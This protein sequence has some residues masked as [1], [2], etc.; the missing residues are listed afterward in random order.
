[1]LL[2]GAYRHLIVAFIETEGNC[3]R[4]KLFAAGEVA[5]QSHNSLK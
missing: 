5:I 1:M 4:V 3:F 2:E